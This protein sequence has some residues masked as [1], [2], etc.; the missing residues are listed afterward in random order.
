MSSYSCSFCG[1]TPLHFHFGYDEDDELC[2]QIKDTMRLLIHDM[3]RRNVR[4]FYSDCEM[5]VSMWGAEIVA[6][7]MRYS[8]DIKLNCILPYE[9]QATKWSPELRD[10][11]FSILEKSSET[12]YIYPKYTDR[13]YR[14]C[15]RYLVDHTDK[16]IAVQDNDPILSL[17][18]VTQFV[19]YAKQKRKT[20]II[21]DPESGLLRSKE[22]SLLT[23][24]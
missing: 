10:R 18:A 6:D 23:N 1:P 5:G 8:K 15:G 13:C 19:S 22:Y 17:D 2:L 16:V 21:I 24:C 11:Y 9:E 14:D 20:I 4:D 7:L 3:C 12:S